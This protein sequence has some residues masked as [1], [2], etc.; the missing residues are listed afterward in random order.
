ME[1]NKLEIDFKK[2]LEQRTIRP[3]EMAWDRL[4]AMLSVTEESKQKQPKRTWMY[5]AASFIG[6]ILIGTLFFKQEVQKGSTTKTNTTVVDAAPPQTRAV[7]VEDKNDNTVKAVPVI[8]NAIATTTVTKK[9]RDGGVTV[10][11]KSHTPTGTNGQFDE[12]NKEEL[13][14]DAASND[15]TPANNETELLLASSYANTAPVKKSSVKVNASSLL[16]S[17]EGELDES[18]RNK[19]LQAVSKNFNAV[20]SS[21]ANRNHN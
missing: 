14:A 21:L 20:K 10:N 13:V 15:I 3:S 12:S 11:S 17:V 2:K 18:F 1:P 19:A 8:Q 4:D 16:S 7:E 9:Y 6:F 5:I